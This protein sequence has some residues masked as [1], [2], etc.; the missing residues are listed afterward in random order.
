MA[1]GE[2]PPGSDAPTHLEG[3]YLS[4]F[5]VPGYE[6]TLVG[7]NLVLVG[8]VS[9][10]QM[11][12]MRCTSVSWEAHSGRVGVHVENIGEL[13]VKPSCLKL[14]RHGRS[15]PEPDRGQA[16]K[17]ARGGKGGGKNAPARKQR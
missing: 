6:D 9:R 5:L 2:M 3:K 10:P 15:P 14:A 16:G 8:L 7:Q 12:G 17:G 1:S 4:E 11:N 13:S